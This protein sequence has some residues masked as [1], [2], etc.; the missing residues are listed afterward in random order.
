LKGSEKK[1]RKLNRLGK[2]TLCSFILFVTVFT[3]FI[4]DGIAEKNSAARKNIQMPTKIVETLKPIDKQSDKI[5]G[6]TNLVLDKNPAN[7]KVNEQNSA[8]A[9]DKAAIEEDIKKHVQELEKHNQD[10]KKHEENLEQHK[11]D[12]EKHE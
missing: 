11:E 10:M 6:K 9:D 8:T 5:E 12:I 3:Y 4:W 2:M 1:H 7:P